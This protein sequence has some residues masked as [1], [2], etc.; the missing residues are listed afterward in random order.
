MK[1]G[2][3][4]VNNKKKKVGCNCQTVHEQFLRANF[5][6]VLDAAIANK[7]AVVLELK[8]RVRRA[9]DESPNKG[10]ELKEVMAELDKVAARKSRLIEM[11]LDGMIKRPEF[12]KTFAGYEK[13]QNHLQKRLSALDSENKV[14]EDLRQKLERIDQ[15]VENLARL[16]EF[17]DSICGEVLAKVVVEGRDKMTFYLTT[18]ENTNP[19]FFKIPLLTT[20][21]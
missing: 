9:I 11:Y 6:A 15:A 8:E 1:Y 16:K 14:A 21:Y 10:T 2:K 7:D 18:G 19:V 17:G 13:Q 4:K 3:E 5:L 12:E 20:R